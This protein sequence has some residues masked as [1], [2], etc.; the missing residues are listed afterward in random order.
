MKVAIGVN[1][2]PRRVNPAA[3]VSVSFARFGGKVFFEFAFL[4][5][6]PLTI[7]RRFTLFD[8]IGPFFGIF[9]VDFQPFVETRFCVRFD[10]FRRA[11]R[12]TDPTVDAFVRVNDEH[13]LAFIEAI[14]RA[15]FN[16]V[17]IFA[18][19]TVV[20]D[21]IGHVRRVSVAGFERLIIARLGVKQAKPFYQ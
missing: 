3:R 16:A 7:S 5:I 9:G 13:I 11:F 15:N 12:F 17:H 2:Y 14:D 20:G 4:A 8:D 21:E 6:E 19:D 18:F 1:F 10:G